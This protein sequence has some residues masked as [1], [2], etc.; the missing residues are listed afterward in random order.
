MA[1]IKEIVQ[2]ATGSI[3]SVARF[4]PRNAVHGRQLSVSHKT[5]LL[6]SLDKKPHRFFRVENLR[7]PPSTFL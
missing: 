3:H 1:K 2:V 5:L 7:C 6:G 4:V